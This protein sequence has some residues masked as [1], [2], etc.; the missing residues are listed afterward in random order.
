MNVTNLALAAELVPVSYVRQAAEAIASRE[1]N[2]KIL[3]SQVGTAML[4]CLSRREWKLIFN[5]FGFRSASYPRTDGTIRPS[6][7]FSA[8]WPSWTATTFR[9]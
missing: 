3:L 4:G 7:C 2:I 1:N 5:L 8:T 9:V 6:R